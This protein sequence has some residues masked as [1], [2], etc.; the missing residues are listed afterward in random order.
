MS[1]ILPFA[2]LLALSTGC[3]LQMRTIRTEVSHSTLR[4]DAPG[5]SDLFSPSLAADHS[6]GD[7]SPAPTTTASP[8][9][10]VG[11]PAKTGGVLTDLLG[12]A[13]TKPATQTAAADCT[14]DACT[15]KD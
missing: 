15:I 14:G 7:E 3:T 1:K 12:A 5:A 9:T 11:T 8:T 2:L 13:L 6:G 4:L 10:T